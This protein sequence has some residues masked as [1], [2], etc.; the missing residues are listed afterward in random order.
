MPFCASRRKNAPTKQPIDYFVGVF[1]FFYSFATISCMN[2]ELQ[3]MNFPSQTVCKSN[4]QNDNAKCDTIQCEA[5]EIMTLD[6][7]H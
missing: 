2:Y 4:N 3:I 5:V 6:I 1:A 7:L